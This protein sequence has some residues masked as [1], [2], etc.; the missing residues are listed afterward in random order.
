MGRVDVISVKGLDLWFNSSD[1]LPPHV[2]VGK[3]GQWEVRVYILETTRRR[4]AYDAKWPPGATVPAKMA[5]AL[6]EKVAENRVALLAEWEAKVL[7]TEDI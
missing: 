7:V 1:H 4:L 2:H 5:K 3:A 6:R